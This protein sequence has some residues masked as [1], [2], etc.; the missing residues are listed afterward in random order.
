MTRI[1]LLIATRNAHKARE[2]ARILPPQFELKT[3]A[4]L[5]GAPDPEETGT[6]FA[7]N[8]AIK[9]ESI[10]AVF[11]GLVVSDD[12][13][14][15]VDALGGMPGVYSARYAGTHGDDEAN[16][17]KMLAEL[18]ARPESDKPFT[19]RYVCAISVAKEGKELASFIGTVEGQIT[20]NPRGTGGFGY[21]P[22]FIP[23]G[24]D[25]AMA[26]ISAEEKNAISHRGEALRKFEAW[27]S[28]AEAHVSQRFGT[29]GLT[30]G[31]F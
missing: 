30:I 28:Q 9:A 25:C 14:I 16:N 21:D 12:S 7:A 15:C 1:P 19:A 4:D 24:Y 10:S 22:L 31:N 18:A 5:P 3:L 29:R 2:F 23:E 26:E 17:R 27:L 8:A 13:G 6:T 20:L 11:P